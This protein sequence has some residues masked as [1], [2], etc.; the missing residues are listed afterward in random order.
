M[1]NI[2]RHNAF[3]EERGLLRVE[4]RR[5]VEEGLSLRRVSAAYTR[6]SSFCVCIHQHQRNRG[7]RNSLITSQADLQKK[8][9]HKRKCDVSSWAQRCMKTKLLKAPA[10]GKPSPPLQEEELG[11]LLMCLSFLPS[12]M[13]YRSQNEKEMLEENNTY[14]AGCVSIYSR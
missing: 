9:S 5:Q 12:L 6:P 13:S 2:L 8:K 10:R 7:Q 3:P 14:T 4:R 1:G 11:E